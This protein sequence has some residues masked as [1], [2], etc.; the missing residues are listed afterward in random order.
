MG[1]REDW[2]TGRNEEWANGR[3]EQWVTG[4]SWP[5]WSGPQGGVGHTLTHFVKSI[6]ICVHVPQICPRRRRS[7]LPVLS[8]EYTDMK[9]ATR[10]KNKHSKVMLY[11]LTNPNIAVNGTC[12]L[13]C[14]DQLA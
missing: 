1:H 5:Q 12:Q 3:S 6:T 7:A 11:D 2:A 10:I 4:R 9:N 14:H 13:Y 8:A